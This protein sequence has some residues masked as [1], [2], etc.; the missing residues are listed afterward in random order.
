MLT[1]SELTATDLDSDDL[2]LLYTLTQD[3]ESG[4][5]LFDNGEIEYILTT[6]TEAHSFRQRD[7]NEGI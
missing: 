2:E 1:G 5:L 6:Q 3:P 7:V 4:T